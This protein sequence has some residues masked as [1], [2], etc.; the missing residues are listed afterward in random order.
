[1]RVYLQDLT[2][3]VDTL[4]KFI[5]AND[6]IRDIN[7]NYEAARAGSSPST[8]TLENNESPAN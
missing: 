6:P 4:E 5:L 8:S 3:V 1:M 7:G 2:I